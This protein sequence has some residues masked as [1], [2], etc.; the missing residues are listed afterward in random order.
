MRHYIIECR[1]AIQA[2]DTYVREFSEFLIVRKIPYT[3]SLHLNAKQASKSILKFL[4]CYSFKI[5]DTYKLLW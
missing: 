4:Y 5:E 1:V 2:K 3:Y